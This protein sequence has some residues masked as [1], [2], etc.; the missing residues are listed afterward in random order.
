[1][2]DELS[3]LRSL[4]TEAAQHLG[5]KYEAK[6]LFLSRPAAPSSCSPS[7]SFLEV[8]VPQQQ[9]QKQQMQLQAGEHNV[10]FVGEDGMQVCG[11]GTAE[12]EAEGP[13]TQGGKGEGE[14]AMM[15]SDDDRDVCEEGCAGG[16]ECGGGEEGVTDALED[17]GE[18]GEREAR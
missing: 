3:L 2:A 6:T 11:G 12:V 18:G 8:V 7:S 14:R 15:M 4:R 9:Q 1:M 16:C 10:E 13:A 5:L 17:L